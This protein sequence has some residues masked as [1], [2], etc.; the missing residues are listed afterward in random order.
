MPVTEL[1]GHRGASFEAPENTLAAF[2]LAW[3]EGADGIEGD[4]RLSRDGEIVCL[5]D[6]TTRRTAGV[7]LTVADSTLAQLR[8]LDVGSWKGDKWASEPIPTLRE[9]IATVPSGKRLFIEL[10][11]GPEILLPLAAILAETG[12]PHEQAVILSFDAEVVAEARQLLPH[13]KALWITDYKRDWQCGGWSPSI[14]EILQTLERT[15]AMGL[16]SR[17]HKIVDATFVQA[18]RAAGVELPVWSVDS[19]RTAARLMALGADS[20]TTNRPGWLR[21]GRRDL[22]SGI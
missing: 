2:R 4:F 8:E 21:N 20:I 17:A 13:V 12:L 7:S 14:G 6:P 16:A 19:P 10:K 18:L 3:E 5:H 22:A 9:V 1:I 15:G 11:S